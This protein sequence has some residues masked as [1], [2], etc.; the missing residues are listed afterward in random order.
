MQPHKISN[1]AVPHKPSP[2][3][4][5]TPYAEP[6]L[7][8]S[9]KAG[10]PSVAMNVRVRGPLAFPL[11]DDGHGPDGRGQGDFRRPRLLAPATSP[12][13]HSFNQESSL[14]QYSML[15]QSCPAAP[16]KSS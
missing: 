10:T 6:N 11:A 7:S 4:A 1:S 14:R 15:Y 16:R 5:G 12:P 2:A 13:C 3:E 8:F 9:R